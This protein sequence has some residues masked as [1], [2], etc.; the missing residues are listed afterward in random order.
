MKKKKVW[1]K[2]IPTILAFVIL[3]GSIILTLQIIK[4]QILFIGRATP[5]TTPQNIKITN[6]T[7]TSFTVTFTTSAK[8][9]GGVSIDGGEG[10][11][12][13]ALDDTN[14][15]GGEQ[16]QLFSHHITV[17]DLKQKT[18][19]NFQ[20]I[21]DSESYSDSGKKYTVTTG[22]VINTPPTTQKPIFGKV[23]LPSGEVASDTLIIATADDVQTLSTVTKDSGE[24][25]IPV[26]SAR[27]LTLESYKNFSDQTL[28]TITARRENMKSIVTLLYKD[29]QNI[30]SITL[31][32]DYDF[33]T[34]NIESEEA[35]PTS[36]LKIPTLAVKQGEVRIIT[37]KKDE[38]FT[39]QQPRFQGVALPSQKVK[40]TIHSDENI[41]TEV[42]SDNNGIWTYRPPKD[43][44]PGE[45]TI[46]IETVD[47]FGVIRR[48]TQTFT[49]F[50]SG[51]QLSLDATGTPTQTPT[52]TPIPSPTLTGTPTISPAG[53][54]TPTTASVS[55][56]PTNIVPSPTTVTSTVAPTQTPPTPKPT[57]TS[58][59]G[60]NQT[61]ILS[62]I[63]ALFIVTGTTLLFLL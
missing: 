8:A 22:P 54:P 36:S 19:H 30:P 57:I 48:I 59:G 21:S 44:S 50:A 63:S 40:I 38:R 10:G 53:S 6:I 1:E 39:D 62:V 49:V 5:D 14:K 28:I 24:F 37:P 61:I 23:L 9:I 45:H 3:L 55:P 11:A 51:S 41:V 43:L 20:I 25:T 29:A 2:R 47:G 18:Q 35:T 15:S 4:N 56:S 46:T 33:K 31:S 58:P 13:L 34:P 17:G 12:I 32:S 7:D 42:K 26:N 27:N 16:K 52:N 60:T